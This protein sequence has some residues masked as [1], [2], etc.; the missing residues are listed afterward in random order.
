MLSGGAAAKVA[1][2]N[3]NLAILELGIVERMD[4]GETLLVAEP[5][6]LRLRLVERL[7]EH[8]EPE[9]QTLTQ[10]A[11]AISIGNPVIDPER[12]MTSTIATLGMSLRRS[13]SIRTGRMLE[14]LSPFFYEEPVDANNVE[15]MRKVA[16]NVDVPMAAGER[17]YTR[18]GF[19]P[20]IEG[21][22]LDVIQPDLGLAGGISETRKIA[23]YAET[24][25]LH[26]QP[27][28]CAGPVATA[29]ALHVDACIPNF[30]IQ[31]FFPFRDPSFYEL[32]EDA[33]DTKAVDSFI[34]LPSKPGLGVE[35]NDDV[36]ARYDCLVIG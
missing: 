35:L 6:C 9:S 2:P 5:L 1:T 21:Q 29:A 36:M 31:E 20:Y 28:N 15:M 13:A 7:A 10:A 22:I 34:D 30:I 16:E 32:V 4:E 8:F 19:R 23:N 12:S 26:V 27:H 17:L 25:N 33:Y 18:Y 24:Y 14:E 3:Q 11:F